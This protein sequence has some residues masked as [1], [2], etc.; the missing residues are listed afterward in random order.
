VASSELDASAQVFFVRGGRVIGRKGFHAE[1][2][3][4]QS[5][6]D[7]MALFV[8]SLYGEQDGVPGEVLVDLEPSSKEALEAWLTSRRG[9]P[10]RIRI[11]R[12]GERAAVLEMV[13]SN[14]EESLRKLS[15]KRRTDLAAR[16][17]A[18]ADL[19]EELGLPEAPLRIECFDISTLQGEET[20]GS[21]VVFEDGLPRKSDYRR[22]KVKE[23]DG[24]DDFK[25]M[26]EVVGRRFVR[27]VQEQ[28]RETKPG[29]RPRK[30]AYRPQLVLIDG[31]RGQ[32]N[33][34]LDAI[35]D[36]GA[37][38][39]PV[40]ALAKRLEE[41]YVPGRPDPIRIP[42]SSEALYILQ[43]VRDEAHRFAI[44]YHRRR[45]GEAVRRSELDGI[46][47]VGRERKALL[48]KWFGSVDGVRKATVD[49]IRAVP[50]IPR[51][52]AEDIHRRLVQQRESA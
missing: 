16:S 11:P 3:E 26:G 29:E 18:L 38:G 14:A 37:E 22:F 21:M 43:H 5:D 52:L 10:V 8:Q 48:L 20:V 49:E 19:Q 41:V 4:E 42:R 23:Q 40:A 44:N 35:E 46:P 50:G 30:F 24:M 12:S 45:R 32:L 31:G 36:A 15:S 27:Y 34:A 28:K 39:I 47:G 9:K 6:A 1:V 33:A 17:R 13:R 2:V 25:A 7:R 51:H